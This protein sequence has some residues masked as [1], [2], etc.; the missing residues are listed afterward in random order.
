MGYDLSSVSIKDLRS[1]RVFSPHSTNGVIPTSLDDTKNLGKSE[2]AGNCLDGSQEA[3]ENGDFKRL[4]VSNED[5]VQST[6]PDA[7]MFGAK[8]V[9]MERNG[10]DFSD[11]K[12]PSE[13]GF[14]MNSI[15]TVRFSI[16][17]FFLYLIS[18]IL[19]LIFK[20]LHDLNENEFDFLFKHSIL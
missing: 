9:I 14:G 17:G 6:P 16:M 5:F 13:K 3:V 19:R 10:S 12:K 20:L 4:G 11:E 15:K 7:E 18:I 2:V 8:Q 1:R